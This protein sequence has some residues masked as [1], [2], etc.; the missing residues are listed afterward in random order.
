MP[1]GLMQLVAYGA[2]NLFLT[3]NPQMT[4]FKTVYRRHTNYSMEYIRNYFVSIPTMS[5][6]S[7]IKLTAKIE[8][9]GDLAHD[10]YFVFDL[11]PIY[12]GALDNFK[13]VRNIGNVLIDNVELIIAGHSIDK[14]YGQ[15]MHIWN[16]LTLTSHKK[17]TY[18]EM[19]GNVPQLYNPKV[20]Y[21]NLLRDELTISEPL[22]DNEN[23]VF[24]PDVAIF[25][26]IPGR[27]LYIPLNFWFCEN[28]GLAIPLISLQYTEVFINIELSP[29]NKLFTVGSNNLSP[30]KLFETENHSSS[31]PV[32]NCVCVPTGINWIPCTKKCSSLCIVR[33][34]PFPSTD[35][36]ENADYI[37]LEDDEF[38]Q[39]TGEYNDCLDSGECR[40]WCKANLFWKY[41]NG[42]T[43]PGRWN[44]NTYIDTN[45]IFLD[46]DERNKFAYST[47]E[48]IITQ[49]QRQ[50]S[51]GLIE[52]ESIEL[53]MTHPIKEL[54]WVFQRDDV[55][56]H[57][58]W[59]NYTNEEHIDDPVDL[60]RRVELISLLKELDPDDNLF[61]ENIYDSI[62]NIRLSSSKQIQTYLQYQNLSDSNCQS[63]K[64]IDSFDSLQ[65]IMFTSVLKFN[66]QQRN[67]IRDHTYYEQL[68][69]YRYHT[70]SY[71][72]V[73]TYSFSLHPE[74]IAPSGSA[75]FSRI[76]QVEMDF[77]LRTPP[78]LNDS[79][80]QKTPEH[81]YNGYIYARNYNVFRVMAGIGSIVFAS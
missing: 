25:P 57:N 59:T 10:T 5:T 69:N 4:F 42:T 52:N 46:T 54:V 17:K 50:E 23:E 45:Y 77:V 32:S 76:D 74:D 40:R 79:S 20:Y 27:R 48:Y 73:Y 38:K 37:N 3:G 19:T 53:K 9:N 21:G 33:G 64:D 22:P 35:L 51:T 8:R 60:E 55:S 16:E 43:T 58:Q 36:D 44:N 30:D 1:G 71:P 29:M 39:I 70:N 31:L 62:L 49:V 26:T 15:W 72:G 80:L 65:N 67:K 41:V 34:D 68:Q 78:S 6:T 56:K 2:E 18:Y 81:A 7:T 63:N 13:W 24:G 11:P 75:N 61:P 47:N 66:G 12:S 28:P 14:Q